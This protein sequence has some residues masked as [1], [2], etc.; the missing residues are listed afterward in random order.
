LVGSVVLAPTDP[1]SINF[2]LALTTGAGAGHRKKGEQVV[3]AEWVSAVAAQLTAVATAVAVLRRGNPP[4]DGHD[5]H[6][7]K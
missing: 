7:D 2:L 1:L 5:D 3:G 4:D 6:P